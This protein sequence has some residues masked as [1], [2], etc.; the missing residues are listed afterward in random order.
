MRK[1]AEP[2]P[3][4]EVMKKLTYKDGHFYWNEDRLNAIKAGTR[5]GHTDKDGYIK[6]RL[7]VDGKPRS[8]YEHRLVW[9][10]FNGHLPEMET[11][12][13]NRIKSDNRIENLRDVPASVNQHNVGVGKTNTSGYQ[14]VAFRDGSY[15]AKIRINNVR[16]H[17]G[18]FRTPEDASKA[19]L[20]AKQQAIR[21]AMQKGA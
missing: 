2:I 13:I 7:T 8:Y 12:H 5:A 3:L 16:L 6:I 18:C 10:I 17:L 20:S 4:S 21:A 14:G 15:Q 11:D 9:F 1:A 19:Y